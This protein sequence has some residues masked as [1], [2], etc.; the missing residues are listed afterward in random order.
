MKG[1]YRFRF[2]GKKRVECHL[3]LLSIG[4]CSSVTELVVTLMLLMLSLAELLNIPAKKTEVVLI[5]SQSA[6]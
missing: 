5:V 2:F 3:M 6:F 1:V 4:C